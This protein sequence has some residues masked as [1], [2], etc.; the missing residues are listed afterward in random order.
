[1][2]GDIRVRDDDGMGVEKELEHLR[3]RHEVRALTEAE[4]GFG[5]YRL[6]NGVYG[7]TYAPVLHR[8][9]PLFQAN[10]YHAFEVHKLTDG[11]ILLVG[12]VTEEAARKLQAATGELLIRLYPAPREEAATL[13]S[14]TLS[15]VIRI[16]ENST[17]ET[18]GLEMYLEPQIGTADERR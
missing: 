15:R 6:P 4:E 14:V 11:A 7:F 10:R 18:G 3:A 8:D 1:M 9:F 5:V 16:R 12:F 2:T 17:R 13:V